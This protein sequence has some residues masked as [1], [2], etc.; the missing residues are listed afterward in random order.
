M[1]F[2]IDLSVTL[3]QATDT[4]REQACATLLALLADLVECTVGTDHYAFQHALAKALFEPRRVDTQGRG[5]ALSPDLKAL[6]TAAPYVSRM[7]WIAQLDYKL[8]KAPK[9]ALRKIF[10]AVYHTDAASRIAISE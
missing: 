10:M 1:L 9:F 2:Q 8:W 3:R 7:E 6:Q 5:A 4:F